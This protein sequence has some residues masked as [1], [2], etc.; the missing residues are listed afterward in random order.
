MNFWDVHGI[1]FLIFMC[2]FPR[3]TLLFSSV[4]TGGLLWWLGFIFAP[5]L[6]V[7]IL[8]TNAYWHTNTIL[9][10]ITWIWAFSGESAEKTIVV[11]K[12]RSRY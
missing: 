11:K 12:T 1:W 8:A 2:F 4:V 9:V 7:A 3:L 6:L 10:V 5:R